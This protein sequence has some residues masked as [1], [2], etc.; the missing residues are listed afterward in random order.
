MFIFLGGSGGSCFV[1]WGRALF[2][3][4]NFNSGD[5]GIAV[6]VWVFGRGRRVII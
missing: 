3:N 4:F 1:Y 2:F 5:L 6:F